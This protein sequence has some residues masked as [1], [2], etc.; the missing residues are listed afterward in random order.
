MLNDK[1]D[2]WVADPATTGAP[3]L[4]DMPDDAGRARRAHRMQDEVEDGD[5]RKEAKA[6]RC[7]QARIGRARIEPN[8]KTRKDKT[9]VMNDCIV[10]S[11]AGVLNRQSGSQINQSS[12]LSGTCVAACPR[13]SAKNGTTHIDQREQLSSSWSWFKVMSL[14]FDP[15]RR[16]DLEASASRV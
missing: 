3:T 14:P 7:P 11:V 13:A 10:A 4:A 16:D 12:Y 9:R 1:W 6:R 8:V 2:V 15:A 5:D